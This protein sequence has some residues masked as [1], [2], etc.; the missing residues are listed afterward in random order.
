[1]R[2]HRKRPFSKL[3]FGNAAP[4]ATIPGQDAK[5]PKRNNTFSKSRDVREDRRQAKASSN[6][7]TFPHGR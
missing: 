4:K 7:Q 2:K 1:L 5:P 3:P 6:P